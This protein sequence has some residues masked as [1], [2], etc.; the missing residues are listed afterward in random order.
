MTTTYDSLNQIALRNAQPFRYDAAGNLTDDGQRGYDWDAEQR[1]IRIRYTGSNLST[2]FRYDGLGR[3]I[4]VREYSGTPNYTEIRYL[5]CGERVCQARNGSDTVIRRYYDEGEQ[6]VTSSGATAYYYAQD[7]LG[8][9]RDLVNA[10]G[11]VLAS[12]DYDP[13]GNPTRATQMVRR[14]PTTATPGC[15]TTPPVAC[16]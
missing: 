5:W 4:A 15:S 14:G 9:V 2:E 1:L 7:H 16:T 13:Y 12:Y 8:S 6:L 11:M 3:R 10:S